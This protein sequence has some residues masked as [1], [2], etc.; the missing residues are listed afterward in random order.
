MAVRIMNLKLVHALIG[1]AVLVTLM[2]VVVD[3]SVMEFWSG[4]GCMNGDYDRYSNCGCSAI[5]ENGAYQFTY[6][7]QEIW[8]YNEDACQ[9]EVHTTLDVTT[10]NCG[11]FGWRSLFILC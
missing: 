6:Q 11:P 5:H 7:G 2:T 4:P 1:I 3:A 10:V 8:F 9:G